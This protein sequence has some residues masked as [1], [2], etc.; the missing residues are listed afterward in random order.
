MQVTNDMVDG[1][2]A[3]MEK[4]KEFAQRKGVS[5]VKLTAKHRK[6]IDTCPLELTY[7]GRDGDGEYV[8]V[9]T[10]LVGG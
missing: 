4:A 3:Y 10:V 2:D 6:D 5:D 9:M 8:V 1:L 7:T